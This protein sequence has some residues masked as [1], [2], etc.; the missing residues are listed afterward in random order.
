MPKTATLTLEVSQDLKDRL[1]LLAEKTSRTPDALV[2]TAVTGFVDRELEYLKGIEEDLEDFRTGNVV[3]HEEAMRRI[4]ETI[5]K[6][7]V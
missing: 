2:D 1:D 6:Y 5:A 7:E 3:S 4:R